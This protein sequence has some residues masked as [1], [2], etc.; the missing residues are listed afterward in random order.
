VSAAKR[1][2]PKFQRWRV[3]VLM[4]E[5]LVPP[6]TID[7]LSEEEVAPFKSEWDVTATLATMGHE[8]RPLGL[9]SDLGVLRQAI[10][11]F[12]PHITFNL[13]EEFH[14]VAVYDQHVV[15]YLELMK[16]RYTGCN[17]RGLMLAHDKALSKQVLAYHRIPVPEFAV[18]PLNRRI[19][20]PKRL[21]FPLLVKSLT[22]EG[23]EGIA[24]ASVV[25]D[26]AQLRERVEF[27][28]GSLETDAPRP[29]TRR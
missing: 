2:K 29:R 27:V 22:A 6:A 17:P 1:R 10:E 20:V 24:R 7:G 19:V 3:L 15:S 5:S 18:F 25:H 4:H 28:H 26:E 16:R 23:S 21:Q 12:R 8:V 13:L 11:E 14:G 9:L